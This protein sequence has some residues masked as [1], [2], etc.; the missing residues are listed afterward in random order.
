MHPCG[1]SQVCNLVKALEPL[2]GCILNL[3]AW[4]IIKNPE[5]GTKTSSPLSKI[6]SVKSSLQPN[7]RKPGPFLRKFFVD[8]RK[9]DV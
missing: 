9:D 2:F 7:A 4:G 1:N 8:I 5:K 6:G 3:Q